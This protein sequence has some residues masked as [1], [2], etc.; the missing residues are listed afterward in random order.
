MGIDGA[1]S[2]LS[3]F[4]AAPVL[5]EPHNWLRLVTGT[6]NGLALAG[7]IYPVLNQTL[8]RDWEDRPAL[9]SFRELAVLLGL[10][11]TWGMLVWQ[12]R[13]RW[14][15]VLDDP[16][17]ERRHDYAVYDRWQTAKGLGVAGALVG[18]FLL[19]DLPREVAALAGAGLLLMSR[20]LHS[21]KML[22]LVDWELL[23]LYIGLF[24]VN[25]ALAQTG[26]A[27]AAMQW[28]AQAGVPFAIQ[29][30]SN[31]GAKALVHEA[32]FAVRNGL[33]RDSALA[34]ITATPAQILG[35]A[36]RIGTLAPGR[37]ADVVV[38]SGDPFDPTTAAR[39][40]FV[41]GEE[42]LP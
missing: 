39:H 38:W 1:N 20:R 23:V 12:T 35:V 11:A 8:W 22:G 36:D 40:V 14:R 25:H 6:L 17:P 32:L 42:V 2:Y 7:L 29:T 13:G 4:S 24:V 34:A 16:P 26:L 31:L 33:D 3:L 15:T 27:A 21:H 41:G 37:D 9:S 30:G 19:S 10:A 28:L 18:A 5:Y